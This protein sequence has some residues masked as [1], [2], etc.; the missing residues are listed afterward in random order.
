MHRL[1]DALPDGEQ[2][3]LM[4]QLGRAAAEGMGM[5]PYYLYRQKHMA[6]NQANVG[7][8]LPG[9]ECLYNVDTMEDTVSVLALGAGG[10]SK[11]VTPGRELV[12]RAPNV[13]NVAQYID[14]VDEM[15]DRKRALWP[16]RDEAGTNP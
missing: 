7:Y 4:V 5:A 14:R 8:A 11:R 6:G 13:K 2:V 12:T 9:R 16:L 3:A 10:I 1:M 15:L